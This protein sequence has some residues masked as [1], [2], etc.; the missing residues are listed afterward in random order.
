MKV[1]TIS[2]VERDFTHETSAD[3]SKVFRN[4]DPALHPFERAREVI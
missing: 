2:R 1:K 4:Y 3:K